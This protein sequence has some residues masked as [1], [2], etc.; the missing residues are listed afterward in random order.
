MWCGTIDYRHPTTGKTY[1]LNDDP[2]VLICRVRVYLIEK[3]LELNGQA[4]PAA[5]VDFALYFYHNYRQLIEKGSAPYFIS[6][7]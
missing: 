1:Q 2:A 5:L 6:R 7:N 4:V 3:H